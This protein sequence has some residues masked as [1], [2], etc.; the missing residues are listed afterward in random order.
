MSFTPSVT[1]T[2]GTSPG[3]VN[4]GYKEADRLLWEKYRRTHSPADRDALL[5]RFNGIIQAA[6]NKWAGP[7]PRQ[8]LLSEAK[9]LAIKAFDTYSPTAGA[10]LATHVTNGLQPLSRI[11]YTYQNSARIPENTA[12]RI[13]TYNSAVDTLK[14]TYGREPT[15][16]ELHSE[17]GWSA[18]EIS[19]VR[20]YNHR[21]LVESGPTVDG[22]F[23]GD[24]N[25]A[26][27][28]SLAGIYAELTPEEKQLFE[29]ITGYNH[30][31][32]MSNRQIMDKMGWTQ[33]QLSYKKTLL[34]K[35]VRQLQQRYGL[36]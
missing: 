30:R 13:A 31:P 20:D 2:E 14:A 32:P 17:L 6:V 5:Q 8:V 4:S 9:L 33:A 18:K 36:L 12:M 23:F 16:D 25:D 22:D 1:T 11:V 15:T 34:T 7:V 29:Q 21:D 3:L 35:K 26:S 27:E 10:A 24:G 28:V 19:K